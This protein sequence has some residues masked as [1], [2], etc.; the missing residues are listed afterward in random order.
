MSLVPTY[1]GLM[2]VKR[3]LKVKGEKSTL[4]FHKVQL[5]SGIIYSV[6]IKS[7]SLTEVNAF[8]LLL[9]IF[10]SVVN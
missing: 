10:L 3:E 6:R 1:N 5:M 9:N 4:L 8:N 7:E 2:I